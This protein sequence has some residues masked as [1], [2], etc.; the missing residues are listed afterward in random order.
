LGAAWISM[1]R[2]SFTAL[3]MFSRGQPVGLSLPPGGVGNK[4]P[5]FAGTEQED[6]HNFIVACFIS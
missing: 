1:S 5:F 3:G 6:P 4:S 2:K